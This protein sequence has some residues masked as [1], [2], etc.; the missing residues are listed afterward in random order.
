MQ[1]SFFQGLLWNKFKISRLVFKMAACFA[2]FS[3]VSTAFFHRGRQSSTQIFRP[4]F[5]SDP[6]LT[7]YLMIGPRKLTFGKKTDFELLMKHMKLDR[8]EKFS[9]A[10]PTAFCG[11]LLANR[12]E[13]MDYKMVRSKQPFFLNYRLDL[14]KQRVQFME[15]MKLTPLQKRREV[16]RHPPVL[17]FSSEDQGFTMHYLRGLIHCGDNVNGD[18]KFVHFLYECHPKLRSYVFE[19][20]SKLSSICNELG[21][22]NERALKMAINMP[23]FLLW[24]VGEAVEKFR[25][26]HRDSGLP[27]GYNIDF[28][29]APVYPPI[30]N[31][32]VNLQHGVLTNKPSAQLVEELELLSMSDI[33][34]YRFKLPHPK[35]EDLSKFLIDGSRAE[36]AN[37]NAELS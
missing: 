15:E 21:I 27:A 16:E 7:R 23:C 20:E 3:R 24:N 2:V 17:I 1:N 8:Y 36:G 33:L 26:I 14:L 19:I 28:H 9:G 10:L 18:A 34:E 25:V 31:A 11:E 6:K 12:C 29:S 37:E 35:P 4:M 22:T 5:M 30:M 13:D 32:S